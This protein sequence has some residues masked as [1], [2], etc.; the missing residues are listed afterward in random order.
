MSRIL[1]TLLLFALLLA[2]PVVPFLFWG[3]ALQQWGNEFV[4]KIETDKN[5]DQTQLSNTQWY[6]AAVVLGLLSCD[7]FLPIPSSVLSTI[8]GSSLGFV[9]GTLVVTAGMTFSALLA[10][11]IGH[12]GGRRL[13]LRIAGET[14]FLA[15]EK[16]AERN[17]HFVLIACRALPVLAEASALLLGSMRIPFWQR[18]FLPILLSNIAIA[19]AYALL[20][21]KVSLGLAVTISI[22]LPLIVL[23]FI[24]GKK[25]A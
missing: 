22:V 11:L 8:A 4:E 14:D 16:L 2:V 23:L 25:N 9:L 5:A 19:A 13:A 12:L 21:A 1:R 20:G 7:L 6:V 24:K 17:G 15:M 10:W 18:F 3:D